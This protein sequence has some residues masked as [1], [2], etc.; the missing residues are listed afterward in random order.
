MLKNFSG[1]TQSRVHEGEIQGRDVPRALHLKKLLQ[2]GFGFIGLAASSVGECSSARVGVNSR[3]M[4]GDREG[5]GV[6]KQRFM[7]GEY[8]KEHANMQ[9]VQQASE[10]VPQRNE[11]GQWLPGV[12]GN[13]GGR[14][15]KK[16]TTAALEA[17]VASKEGRKA[18]L[19]AARSQVRVSEYQP[20]MATY[21]R[22]TLEG[23][24]TERLEV[25]GGLELAA[26]IARAKK[27][28]AEQDSDTDE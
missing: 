11:H 26:R 22:E 25:Q 18:I 10:Q 7:L 3:S 4:K 17:Y 1:S 19:K 9:L 5:K 14:P 16:P 21:V 28:L 24:L 20:A 13:P 2:H 15:N 27:R 12:C 8:R 23:K 6:R